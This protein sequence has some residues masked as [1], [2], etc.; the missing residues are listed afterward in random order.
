MSATRYQYGANVSEKNKANIACRAAI[1]GA[2]A[3]VEK[4]DAIA[5]SAMRSLR[6][7]QVGSSDISYDS[8]PTEG[9]HTAH[10]ALIAA[11]LDSCEKLLNLVNERTAS[12]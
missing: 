5:A 11:M 7:L 3:E 1:I 9:V 6:L 12:E 4:L 8:W 10:A 2:I